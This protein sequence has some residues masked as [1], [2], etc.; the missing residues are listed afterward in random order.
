VPN[1]YIGNQSVLALLA[2]GSTKGIVFDSGEGCTHVVPI[3]E[4]YALPHSTSS[5]DISG[6]DLT[7][8]MM[9][10]LIQNG[11]TFSKHYDVDTIKQI[12]ETKTYIS[13]NYESE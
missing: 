10:L 7:D 6:K 11:L 8:H 9:N 13:L 12:K 3:Y 5:L 2:S 1:F 4:A